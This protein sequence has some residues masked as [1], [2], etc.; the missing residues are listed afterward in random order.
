MTYVTIE[1][2]CVNKCTYEIPT[3]L[4]ETQSGL[5]HASL[6]DTLLM[7]MD[8]QHAQECDVMSTSNSNENDHTTNNVDDV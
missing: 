5:H 3:T 2:D 1:Y 6:I 7:L 4:N 8:A